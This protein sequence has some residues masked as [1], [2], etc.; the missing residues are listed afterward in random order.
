[1]QIIYVFLWAALG[2]LC[3]F[4]GKRLGAVAYML[5]AFFVFMGV[6]YGLRA[7]GGF[8]VFSGL[9][10]WIFRGILVI[11]LAAIVSYWLTHR[12]R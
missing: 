1:M 8:E 10:G 3:L 4:M 7:F 2:V 6:W 12:K 9:W 5:T 11:F